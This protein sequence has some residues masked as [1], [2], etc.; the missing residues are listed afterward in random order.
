M[1]EERITHEQTKINQV[2]DQQ[3]KMLENKEDKSLA[4]NNDFINAF[5]DEIKSKGGDLTPLI[6]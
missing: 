2:I 3:L 5:Y 4:Y 6:G 1:S